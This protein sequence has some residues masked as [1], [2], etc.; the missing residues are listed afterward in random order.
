MV[1]QVVIVAT[2][3]RHHA[4]ARRGEDSRSRIALHHD[5]DSRRTCHEVGERHVQRRLGAIVIEMVRVHIEQYE[6]ARREIGER[7]ETLIGLHDQGV[8]ATM[9][10][11]PQSRDGGTDQPRGVSAI[12]A[13]DKRRHGRS[14]RL[15]VRARD[16]DEMPRL[17]YRVEG[18]TANHE[19]AARRRANH[20]EVGG[21]HRR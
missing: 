21:S 17:T 11:G 16:G 13:R 8:V 2:A 15:P 14:R 6:I 12:A 4:A 10:V 7:P 5:H 1:D 20:I 18:L 9:S 19:V 3:D